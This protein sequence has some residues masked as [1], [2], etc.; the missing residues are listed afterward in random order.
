M[1][2]SDEAEVDE[3]EMG[4]KVRET[5]EAAEEFEDLRRETESEQVLLLI[6]M[7]DRTSSGIEDMASELLGEKGK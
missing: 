4:K 5:L 6:K 7:S 3:K 2:F 1:K